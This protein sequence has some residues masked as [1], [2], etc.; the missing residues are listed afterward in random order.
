MAGGNNRGGLRG[1]KK[2]MTLD[3]FFEQAQ[4]VALH[5]HL[6]TDLPPQQAP[7]IP[8]RFKSSRLQARNPSVGVP[9]HNRLCPEF[10]IPVP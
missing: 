7:D 9:A 5:L 8:L 3:P 2:T 4:N 10:L 6:P 1:D